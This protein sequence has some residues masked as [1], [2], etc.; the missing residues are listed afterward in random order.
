MPAW[1][2][3]QTQPLRAAAEVISFLKYMLMPWIVNNVMYTYGPFILLSVP[4]VPFAKVDRVVSAET[5]AF[6]RAV[7]STLGVGVYYFNHRTPEREKFIISVAL[8]ATVSSTSS[9]IEILVGYLSLEFAVYT[10][11]S[12]IAT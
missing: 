9:R 6:P 4:S 1:L 5:T 8:E 10:W 11:V 12:P 7:V 3:A 2:W